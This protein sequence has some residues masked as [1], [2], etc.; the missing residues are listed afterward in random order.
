MHLNAMSSQSHAFGTLPAASRCCSSQSFTCC[1]AAPALLQQRKHSHSRSS[2]RSA[3]RATTRVSA[4]TSSATAAV[5]AAAAVIATTHP[6]PQPLSLLSEAQQSL[7]LAQLGGTLGIVFGGAFCALWILER[8]AA[9][10]GAAALAAAKG[11]IANREERIA[12]LERE[13]EAERKVRAVAVCRVLLCQGVGAVERWLDPSN[14][15]APA[16]LPSPLLPSPP[17]SPP[18][19]PPQAREEAEGF[20][21]RLGEASRDIMKLEKALGIKVRLRSACL[22]L[23][24]HP[25]WLCSA[26]HCTPLTIPSQPH[27][28]PTSTPAPRPHPDPENRTA[29]WTCSSTRRAA[30]SRR[31][32][33]TS[34]SCRGC[35]V[36]SLGGTVPT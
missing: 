19:H 20:E 35:P 9:A 7:D 5:A 33:R 31:W 14:V 22:A 21:G 8:K 25:D 10:D 11:E 29:S 13:L 34:K 2:Q 16:S 24:S 3:R 17:R 30:R 23:T 15:L 1:T 27:L 26:Q 32:R 12:G 28:N 18:P 36:D 4:L 6:L